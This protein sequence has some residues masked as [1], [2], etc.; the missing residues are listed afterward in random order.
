[1]AGVRSWTVDDVCRWLISIN[2][3]SVSTKLEM[4]GIDG[5]RL[6]MLNETSLTQQVKIT[7]PSQ[8]VAL[9]AA[10]NVLKGSMAPQRSRTMAPTE[11]HASSSSERSRSSSTG[12]Q[13]KPSTRKS[14]TSTTKHRPPPQAV[15]I[16]PAPKLLDEYC[17]HSGWIRKRGGSHKTCEPKNSVCVNAFVFM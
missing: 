8:K 11:T 15:V 13:N 6:L 9:L 5:E 10:I 17:N 12:N 14:L 1:M 4:A 2:M 16:A 3:A 7:N